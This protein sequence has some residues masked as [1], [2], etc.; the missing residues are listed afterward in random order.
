MI[1]FTIT[2][3]SRYNDDKYIYFAENGLI[4]EMDHYDDDSTSWRHMEHHEYDYDPY[5]NLILKLYENG[6]SVYKTKYFYEVGRG[7]NWQTVTTPKI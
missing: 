3:G 7:N 4:K 1:S 6:G 2:D 5:G